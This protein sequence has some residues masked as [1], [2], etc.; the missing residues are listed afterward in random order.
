MKKILIYLFIFVLAFSFTG[1]GQKE[2]LEKKAGEKLTE[3]VMEKAGVDVDIDGDKVVI[4]GE[5]GEEMTIGEN[6]W[7]TSD[8]AKSIPK[9]KVGK[10]AAVM[11][12]S[13]SVLIYVDEASKEDITDYMDEIKKTFTEDSYDMS[14]DGNVTYG[15]KNSEGIAVMLTY[16][17]G[18]TFGI[19][20]MK[21]E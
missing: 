2:K 12:T 1:C 16:V 8:L 20:V 7:P 15:A 6:E 13:D 10:V 19:T 18:E 14:S 3:K 17:A 11:E 5:D 4:K 21:G 9:F